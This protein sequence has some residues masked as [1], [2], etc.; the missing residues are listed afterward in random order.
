MYLLAHELGF[1]G[2]LSGWGE[3]FEQRLDPAFRP[4]ALRSGP[5][6]SAAV[7]CGGQVNYSALLPGCRDIGLGGQACRLPQTALA[8]YENGPEWPVLLLWTGAE[9]D[10]A[11]GGSDRVCQAPTT[12][13]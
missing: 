1:R 6:G 7:R 5:A 2:N 4:S 3:A 13:T 8:T 9:G 11:H 12:V 10:L